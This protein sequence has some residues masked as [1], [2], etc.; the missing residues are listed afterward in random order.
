MSSFTTHADVRLL[1]SRKVQLLAPFEYHVGSLPSTTVISVP[2]GFISDL[3]STPRFMWT[4]FPPLDRYS[5]AAILHD[6]MYKYAIASK[7]YADGVF[8]EA[9]EVLGVPGWKRISLYLAVRLFG[10]GNYV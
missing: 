7:E 4:I 2:V 5:K 8:L 10:R 3:A 6:Y 1:E 9:M